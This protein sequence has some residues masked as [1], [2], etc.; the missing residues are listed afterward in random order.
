MIKSWE[1]KAE[2][3]HEK[4]EILAAVE[5]V[6]NSGCLILGS[7]VKKFEQDFADYCGTRYGVGVDNGTNAIF[8]ALKALGI[9]ENDEVIT[10]SNTA[11]ATVSAIV[12]AGAIPVFVDIE[13]DTF[14]MDTHKIERLITAQTKCILPVHLFGQCVDMDE[15]NRIAKQYRLRVI[16]DC[17][18]SH[19]A[20]YKNRKAGSMSD[21]AATSFYPTKILGTY[22]DGGMVLTN[23][24]EL[25]SKLTRLRF[26]GMDAT[27]HALVHGYNCRL[28][29]IHAAILLKKLRHIENYISQRRLLA[30]HY[31][32][33]LKNTDL[34]LPVEKLDRKHAYYLYVVRH[35]KRDLVLSELKK[36]GIHLNIHYPR[37]I[38][39]MDAY[40][41]LHY[42]TGDLP[43]TERIANEIFSL[44]LYPS[45]SLEKLQVVT[46]SLQEIMTKI[47]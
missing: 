44:P 27:G 6:L 33:L 2:Y 3:E 43:V 11:V 46:D 47:Q 24:E 19:G 4:E 35:A 9:G 21:I 5:E 7:K 18:Q 28:D 14:L 40:K 38:H 16:E 41:N 13:E 42:K 15:V 32:L 34:V 26:Y 17:A 12:S 10:V 22:G 23:D 37:P 8:L 29:E 45:F 20:T 30:D 39:M 25:Y 1:Y 31:N 36:K